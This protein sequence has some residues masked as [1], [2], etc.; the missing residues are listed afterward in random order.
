VCV[1][2]VVNHELDP[3]TCNKTTNKPQHIHFDIHFLRT[4]SYRLGMQS[5]PTAHV[6]VAWLSICSL[7]A[8]PASADVCNVLVVVP[9]HGAAW[10]LLLCARCCAPP[11]R[12]TSGQAWPATIQN[13]RLHVLHG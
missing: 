2:P 7:V 1:S 12:L 13:K 6:S 10:Q 11:S 9:M 4:S 5:P 8:W 3:G